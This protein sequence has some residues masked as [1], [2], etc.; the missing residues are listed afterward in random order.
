MA[1]LTADQEFMAAFAPLLQG[2]QDVDKPK[3]H[4]GRRA[5]YTSFTAA[6]PAI[7]PEVVFGILQIRR[8]D[9][10]PLKV[11]HLGR[12]DPDKPG[13]PSAVVIHM[14]GVGFIALSPDISVE[15]LSI[16]VLDTGVQAFSVYYR[17]APEH[18]YPA[19]LDDCWTTLTCIRSNAKVLH[20]YSS[21][22]AVM[23]ESAGGTRGDSRNPST[24]H[25]AVTA[26]RTTDPLITYVG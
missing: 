16:I 21:R 26:Y 1:T 24:G 7:H 11:Y 5:R 3:L 4:D 25:W 13:P 20:V 10:T 6:S 2:G 23:G 17:L 14:H 19:A 18:P 9:G 22:I 8:E 12:R 15:R